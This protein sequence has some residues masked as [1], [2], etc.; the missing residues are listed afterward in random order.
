MA[1]Q[2]SLDRAPF[3]VGMEAKSGSFAD[4][5]GCL[6]VTGEP[7]VEVRGATLRKI[8]KGGAA[9]VAT[10]QGGTA[11]TKVGFPA[12]HGYLISRFNA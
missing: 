5:Y 12:R 1:S 11:P 9:S 2:Q 8:A 3:R 4:E 6:D 7:R 10:A